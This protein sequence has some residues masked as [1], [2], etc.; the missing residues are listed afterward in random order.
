MPLTQ[1]VQANTLTMKYNDAGRLFH[2]PSHFAFS[3]S[4]EGCDAGNV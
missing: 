1:Q 4:G 2:G 3:S